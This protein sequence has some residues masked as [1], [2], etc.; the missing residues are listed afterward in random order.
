MP[1]GA[2]TELRRLLRLAASG[3]VRLGGGVTLGVVG[4]GMAPEYFFITTEDGGFLARRTSRR[5]SPH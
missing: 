4:I 5:C 2:G 1:L 3:T